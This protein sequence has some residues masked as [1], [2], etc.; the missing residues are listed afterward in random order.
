[1]GIIERDSSGRI[2]NAYVIVTNEVFDCME[3]DKH[4]EKF[5]QYQNDKIV[6]LVDQPFRG[7]WE[8]YAASL[9]FIEKYEEF[10]YDIIIK[11][12]SAK[13]KKLKKEMGFYGRPDYLV[14]EDGKWKKVE[15]ECWVHKY[16]SSHPN[17]YADIVV[18]YD[19][20]MDEPENLEIITMKN[21]YGTEDIISRLE[22]PEFMYL[23]DQ[24]FKQ[25]YDRAVNLPLTNRLW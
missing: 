4:I 16:I 8:E 23:Y 18:A 25:D 10:G 21:Y 15:I 20:Y 6:Y 5:K 12:H 7:Y 14:M 17:G 11:E 24:D 1:M 22:V 19:N 3:I 13:Y 2:T 9:W